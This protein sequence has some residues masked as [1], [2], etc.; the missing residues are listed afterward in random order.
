MHGIEIDF[1]MDQLMTS[2]HVPKHNYQFKM[3]FPAGFSLWLSS[4][5]TGLNK[6]FLPH[7]DTRNKSSKSEKCYMG[8]KALHS[9]TELVGTKWDCSIPGC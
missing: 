1:T 6:G 4:K 5:T 2:Y 9:N 3:D 8:L 7:Q